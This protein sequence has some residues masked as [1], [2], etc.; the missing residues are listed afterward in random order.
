[1]YIDNSQY[2]KAGRQQQENTTGRQQQVVISR[3]TPT[4]LQQQKGRKLQV[5]NS[6]YRHG[7]ETTSSD[8]KVTNS[9][10]MCK[11]TEGNLFSDINSNGIG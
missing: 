10:D 11:S 5:E 4:S 8:H 6:Q 2:T 3:M 1:M 9:G 7:K